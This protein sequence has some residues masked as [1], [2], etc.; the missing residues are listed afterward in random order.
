MQTE[1]VTQ[2]MNLSWDLQASFNA[3]GGNEPLA[4]DL[5]SMGKG[6]AW[7]NGQSIGRYWMAYA[8][9]SCN[10][11]SYAGTYRPAKCEDGCGQPTQRW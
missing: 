2:M 7:I 9:G 1:S 10:R 3:P 8:K 6:Q 11:C 5:R 4:L